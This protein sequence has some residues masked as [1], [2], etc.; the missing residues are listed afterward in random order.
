[1]Q[2][3]ADRLTEK[4]HTL[5][6]PQ[7]AEVESFVT[8]LQA[9]EHHHDTARVAAPLSEPAFAAVWNNPEDEVYDAL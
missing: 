7:L 6:N 3:V 8:S 1:M 4:L 9:W 5:T 2:T